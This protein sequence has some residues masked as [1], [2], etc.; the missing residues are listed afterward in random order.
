MNE[1]PK[2]KDI[3]LREYDYS[4][5]GY[6]FV[7][8]CTYNRQ[9]LF[10][11]SRVGNDLCV[12]PSNVLQNSIIEKW[13]NELERKF[14]LEIDKYVI[15]PDHVH[16]ILKLCHDAERH[17]GRSLPDIMQWFKTMTTNEYIRHVRADKLRPF[18]SK[19]WQ[20]SY[21]EHIIRDESDYVEKAQYI[22][23]NPITWNLKR[24]ADE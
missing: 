2:R 3:R 22:L 4:Q 20:K 9:Q 18:D 11:M 19:L 5:N 21:Y 16:F 23:N 12:V 14:N 6:Y 15:M 17:T 10:E 24:N 8:I 13:L 1:L 7:T